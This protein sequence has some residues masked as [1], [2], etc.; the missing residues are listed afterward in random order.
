MPQPI[1]IYKRA[2][3]QNLNALRTKGLIPGILYGQSLNESISIE[4]PLKDLQI[5]INETSKSTIFPLQLGEETCQ[6]ILRDYQTDGLCSQILH[7]D[8]QII[9]EGEIIKM[10]IPVTYDGLDY[11]SGKKLILEKSI[12]K[13][14]VKGPI[15]HI[16]ETF[17]INV[18]S[19]ERGAKIC[20]HTISL[21][22]DIELLLHPET[23][24]ATVQ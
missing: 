20:A 13:L 7:V 16:P 12:D 11:L 23:I 17:V 24:I 6:C 9:K 14:L 5:I 19:L 10:N 1:T 21:S 22:Q 3:K 4:I 8:F 15:E 18:G 2:S